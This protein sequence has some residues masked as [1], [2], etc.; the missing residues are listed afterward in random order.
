M[1]RLRKV[2]I[3]FNLTFTGPVL[4]KNVKKKETQMLM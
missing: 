4:P 2:Q 3:S 1:Y